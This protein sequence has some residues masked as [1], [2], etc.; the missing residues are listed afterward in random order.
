MCH[1][2]DHA[3][4]LV[5]P[6]LGLMDRSN[7][8]LRDTRALLVIRAWL[9]QPLDLRDRETLG[10]ALDRVLLTEVVQASF[11]GLG[12]VNLDAGSGL[13][14]QCK[15]LHFDVI[16]RENLDHERSRSLQSWPVNP[17]LCVSV[18]AQL[19]ANGVVR[20]AGFN[21]GNELAVRSVP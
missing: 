6:S 19:G 17:E 1:C 11:V 10:R 20:V 18:S 15:V 9:E 16:L 12:H 13:D 14:N 7:D 21:I 8:P 5:T 4:S 2:L 3:L